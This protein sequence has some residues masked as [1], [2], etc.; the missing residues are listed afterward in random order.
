MLYILLSAG[1]VSSRRK[2]EGCKDFHPPVTLFCMCLFCS[3]GRF[4]HVTSYFGFSC[5]NFDRLLCV[6]E[7]FCDL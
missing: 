5:D 2:G 4:D 1:E 7:K 3:V 6:L